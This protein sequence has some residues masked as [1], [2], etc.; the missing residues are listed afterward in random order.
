V[1]DNF[2]SFNLIETEL[3][4]MP[5]V[6]QWLEQSA[7]QPA[8]SQPSRG[9]V[10]RK[11]EIPEIYNGILRYIDDPKD[12]LSM[13]QVNKFNRRVLR[14][15]ATELQL[16]ARGV[17]TALARFSTA[18]PGQG[19]FLQLHGSVLD[20]RRRNNQNEQANWDTLFQSLR[21]GR[22]PP[23]GI[24]MGQAT[25]DADMLANIVQALPLLPTSRRDSND[26][27]YQAVYLVRAALADRV[28][29][30]RLSPAAR[31]LIAREAIGSLPHLSSQR[32]LRPGHYFLT[33]ANAGM[34][35]FLWLAPFT[36]EMSG[37]PGMAVAPLVGAATAAASPLFAPNKTANRVL[38]L[39][40]A[41]LR[42]AQRG[43]LEPSTVEGITQVLEAAPGGKGKHL[44]KLR[45]TLVRV[46]SD[47]QLNNVRPRLQAAGWTPPAGWPAPAAN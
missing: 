27:Q 9:S 20:A 18:N 46:A 31:N 25:T 30:T 16:R 13:S 21:D 19:S 43:D 23:Q 42:G 37:L 14:G 3:K 32:H 36:C 5:T 33:G 12:I 47:A 10:Q 22:T 7:V 35:P 2:G 34:Q 44:R 24:Q 45:D 40:C 11:M 38:N 4:A 17:R 39:I 6:E 28:R 26:E 41:T 1:L 15:D 29:G 8:E